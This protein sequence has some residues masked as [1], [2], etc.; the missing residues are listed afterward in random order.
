MPSTN[1]EYW[2]K[3]IHGNIERDKLVS[4]T[5][6]KNGWQVIRFW[7]S[8]IKKNTNKVVDKIVKYLNKI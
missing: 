1:V 5:L 6:R 7:E 2:E 8:D 4:K 3:K